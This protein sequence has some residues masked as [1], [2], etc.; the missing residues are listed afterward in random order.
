M[1]LSVLSFSQNIQVAFYVTDLSLTPATPTD[2]PRSLNL[3]PH[4]IVMDAIVTAIHAETL[5]GSSSEFRILKVFSLTDMVTSSQQT[6]IALSTPQ[7]TP[8]QLV[9]FEASDS[10]SDGGLGWAGII[11][12]ILVV[13]AIALAVVSRFEIDKDFG[14]TVVT[15]PIGPVQIIESGLIQ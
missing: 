8:P 13:V 11:I 9:V 3:V 4:S 1:F 15:N 14:T 12:S 6:P 10:E 5:N 2:T 7:T